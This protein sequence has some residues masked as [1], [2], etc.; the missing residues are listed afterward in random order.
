MRYKKPK[1]S[2]YKKFNREKNHGPVSKRALIIGIIIAAVILAI[3]ATIIIVWA[4]NK[5]N[6]NKMNES[7]TKIIGIQVVRKPD[8]VSYYCGTSLDTKGLVVYTLS[9]GGDFTKISLDACEILGFDSSVAVEEQVITVK[10]KDFTDTFT[11]E[12]KEEAP[13]VPK[14]ESITMQTLPKTEY[15][16]K[17]G[18]NTK[19]GVFVCTYTDG[20]TKTVDLINEYIYGFRVAYLSG[21][22]TYDITV[23]YSEN[24][25]TVETTYK[26]TITE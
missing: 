13:V 18:L 19:G 20:T 5:S 16:V 1:Y 9:K 8:K 3:V 10:Y 11:I 26:I 7:N 22:G 4:V 17:E 6:E 24:G 12:I 21:L 2:S 23:K 25:V 14:L 15:K